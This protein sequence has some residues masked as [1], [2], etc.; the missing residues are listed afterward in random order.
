MFEFK[1]KVLKFQLFLL[2]FGVRALTIDDH[3]VGLVTTTES[4]P[5]C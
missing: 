1:E 4:G 3:I 5:D 2:G